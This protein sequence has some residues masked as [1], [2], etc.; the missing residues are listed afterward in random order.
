MKIELL[1]ELFLQL[2]VLLQ[3]GMSND[4]VITLYALDS[5]LVAL[6][7]SVF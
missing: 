2:Y 3:G 7:E 6:S 1:V 5:I 4:K